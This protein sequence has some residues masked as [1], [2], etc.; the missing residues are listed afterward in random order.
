MVSAPF[1]RLPVLP[2]QGGATA[3]GTPQKRLRRAP[4]ALFGGV[5]GGGSPPPPGRERRKPL[6]PR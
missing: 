4:E 6:K 2:L 3:P 5:T 1:Q